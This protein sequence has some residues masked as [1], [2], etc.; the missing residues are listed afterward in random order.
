[1][2]LVHY[3]IQLTFIGQMDD[4]FYLEPGF[5]PKHCTTPKLRN[6]LV[7]LFDKHILP[8][9]AEILAARAAVERST[10]GISNA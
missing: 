1:M 10:K 7:A 3:Y 4:L 8:Q 5:E 2:I 9:A 6:I